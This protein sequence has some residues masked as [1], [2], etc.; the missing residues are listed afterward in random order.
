MTADDEHAD[1]VMAWKAVHSFLHE[2]PTL[3]EW[4]GT[5]YF[6]VREKADRV[7]GLGSHLAGAVRLIDEFRYESALALIRTA[8]E[9]VVVDWLVFS[10]KTYVRRYRR[11][12]EETWAQWQA[13]R[14]A[15]AEWTRTIKDWTRYR[16]GDVRIVHEGLFSEPNEQG[17]RQ[18]ISIY[19]FLLEQYQP[20]MGPPSQ[21]VDDSLIGRDELR[22]L[23][24]ENRAL[25][26]VY[27]TWMSLLRNLQENTLVDE[28]DAGRLA[29]H[30]GFLSGY[31]HPVA[32]QRRATYGPQA[33]FNWPQYDHY[34]SELVLLYA[35][36]L[37]VLEARNFLES[38]AGWRGLSI[39]D[40][41]QVTPALDGAEALI[42]YFWFLGSKP[43]AYDIWKAHSEA[44]L[45]MLRD[46]MVT[47][48]TTS[49]ELPP[50][51]EPRDVPYPRDPLRRLIDMHSDSGG[52]MSAQPY[53]SP[54]PRR[55]AQFR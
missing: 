38:V 51:P 21:Q 53:M 44:I 27:L 12:T 10:G 6:E 1:L 25:W 28:D 45:R 3:L 26:E 15:G 22:Q 47:A 49:G 37:G 50:E 13:D 35:I 8:L 31:A 4:H 30:Y 24:D 9:H 23:A 19:Y 39:A 41:D 29:A 18:Q 43:H 11:V 33:N 17:E 40:L 32:D 54:W 52:M 7:R 46:G 55:D 42:G 48:V 14:A 5:E 2:M 34:S 36:A 16:S 20:A